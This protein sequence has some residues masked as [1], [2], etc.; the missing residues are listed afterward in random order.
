MGVA[1]LAGAAAVAQAASHETEAWLAT[2]SVPR[3]LA[4]DVVWHHRNSVSEVGLDEEGAPRE[5]SRV[6]LAGEVRMV[7]RSVMLFSDVCQSAA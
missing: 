2:V 5:G 1:T 4:S 7:I 6:K 3:N